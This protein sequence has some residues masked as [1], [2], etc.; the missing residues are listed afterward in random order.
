MPGFKEIGLAVRRQA[1]EI[2][3]FFGAAPNDMNNWQK[4]TFV[5]FRPL[6]QS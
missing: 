3:W 2:L 6:L 4:Q 5:T 1:Q